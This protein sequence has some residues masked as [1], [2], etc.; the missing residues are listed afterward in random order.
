VTEHLD[1]ARSESRKGGAWAADR[2][3]WRLRLPDKPRVLEDS[4]LLEYR[5]PAE[6]LTLG[7]A[8]VAVGILGAGGFLFR[9]RDVLIAAVVVYLSML[10]TAMQA[11]TSY[12]LQGAEVTATQFP[13]IYQIFEE[14]RQRLHAP[15][16]RVFVIR[17]QVWR[18]H[19]YGL[20]APYVIVLSS[21]LIDALELEELRYVLGQALGHICFGH[22]RVGLLI[23]G[24]ESALP[25]VLSWVAT[26]RDLIFAAYWRAATTS[27][28]R[29]GI[30][31]CG[32]VVKAIRVQLKISVG[33]NQI[34]EVRAEDLFEQADKVSRGF[35]RLQAMLFR[36][37][38]PI[39]PL[40][41]RL[42]AM[43][44]WAGLPPKPGA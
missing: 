26:V 35:S 38:T 33:A 4:R 9:E 7:L 8:L 39:P 16:T 21:V 5:H 17:Q 2:S 25:A 10:F 6:Y 40:I 20:S 12:R 32:D 43:V 34:G 11:K 19:A 22:T 3:G 24:E 27:D 15:P 36:W 44:E 37:R 23:G 29:A 31:A 1:D 30:L 42:E 18:T 13:A 41:Q 28:D 14:V